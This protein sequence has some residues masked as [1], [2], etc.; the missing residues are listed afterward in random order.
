MDAD[1]P[2][3]FPGQSGDL[4]ASNFS[5]AWFLLEQHRSTGFLDLK[6]GLQHLER[7]VNG[8]KEGE[9][10]FLKANVGSVLEQLD[11]LLELKTSFESD[12]ADTRSSIQ[13]LDTG[14]SSKLSMAFTS[15]P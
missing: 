9:I 15:K 12:A 1:L 2:T 10:S 4:T 6:A 11:T 8:Q 5:P 14:I 3:M 7:K 13:K